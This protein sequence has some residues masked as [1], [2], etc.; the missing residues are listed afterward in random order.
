MYN[1]FWRPV[2]AGVL[3][4]APADG[5]HAVQ[6]APLLFQPV[7]GELHGL[8]PHLRRRRDAPALGAVAAV[9]GAVLCQILV[10]VDPAAADNIQVPIDQECLSQPCPAAPCTVSCPWIPLA[11]PRMHP[12]RTLHSPA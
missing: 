10:E 11:K 9:L 5:G 8:D 12:L 6:G 4:P 1:A 3:L 2:D 7:Q